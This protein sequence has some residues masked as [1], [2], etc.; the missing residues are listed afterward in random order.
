MADAG[1]RCCRRDTGDGLEA[2]RGL[3]PADA[4][5]RRSEKDA[6]ERVWTAGAHADDSLVFGRREGML[7]GRR[8]LSRVPVLRGKTGKDKSKSFER[9]G[10]RR[11]A[12]QRR[13]SC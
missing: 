9:K 2:W 3:G 11:K 12:K 1:D 10:A 7:I 13:V 6:A 4:S 8:V 5:E